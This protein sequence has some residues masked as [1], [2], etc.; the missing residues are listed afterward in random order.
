[1][2]RPR[3]IGIVDGYF[4]RFPAVWH[5]E[6]LFALEQGI[7]VFGSASMGALRA[8]EL[9]PFGMI[10]VGT[11]Y[12]DFRS[13][14]L[15]DD[16][17]VAVAHASGESEFRCLSEAMVN[18][19]A[20]LSAASREGV[21]SAHTRAS[22]FEIAKSLFY[23]ARSWPA[24]LELGAR[25]GLSRAELDRLRAWLPGGRIDLKRRDALAML[26]VMREELAVEPVHA[27]RRLPGFTLEN[28]VYW[29]RARAEAAGVGLGALDGTT[30]AGEAILQELQLRRDARALIDAALLGSALGDE[31]KRAGYAPAADAVREAGDRFR[32]RMGLIKRDQV[33]DWVAAS[34]LTPLAFQQLVEDSVAA[35]WARERRLERSTPAILDHLRLT[36][37]Y[38]GLRR[39]AAAKLRW[40][41][42]RGLQRPSLEDAGTDRA[43]LFRWYFETRLRARV[44][45][46][47]S[48]LAAYWSSVGFGD[49]SA[50]VLALLKEWLFV[51]AGEP[52]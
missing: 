25:E 44:P 23:P 50:F 4:E 6:I 19:R 18:I 14:R 34:D 20:T 52:E 15:E 12:E 51:Q 41:E 11:I 9:E 17:E 47:A 33:L 43:E 2:R 31:A 35:D 3:A 38:A 13:G 29:E 24:L 46:D 27:D 49:E 1:V 10:G 42:S 16:D 21:V 37:D 40:L 39:R 5:K 30:S 26:R 7:P 48:S 45:A 22:L 36:G 28:T 8:A 32:R